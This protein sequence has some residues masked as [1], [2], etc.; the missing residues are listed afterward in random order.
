MVRRRLDHDD[1]PLNKLNPDPRLSF[2]ARIWIPKS[3]VLKTL[4]TDVPVTTNTMG[5]YSS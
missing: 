2:R 3:G 4:G 1:L 5:T